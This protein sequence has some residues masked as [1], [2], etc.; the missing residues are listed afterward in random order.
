MNLKKLKK[1]ETFFKF[2]SKKSHKA[3][4]FFLLI[5]SIYYSLAIGKSWDEDF[6]LF[7]GKVTLDYLF[8]FGKIDKDYLYREYFSTI[9]WSLKYFLTLIFP[10]KYQIEISHLINLI[11]SLSGI[12]AIG[13]LSKELFNKKVGKIVFL[14]LFFYP[15]FFGHMAFN[16]KDMVLAVCHV[17]IFYLVI[18]YLKKQN[19]KDKSNY[20]VIFLGMLAAIATGIHIIFL[21]ALI[22]IFLFVLIEIFILKK[23]ISKSF[24]KKKLYVDLIKT[25]LI[26]Y[27]LLI[28]F[29]IDT[30]PNI[31]ILP[32]NIFLEHFKLLSG[33][34]WRGWPYNLLNGQYYL[35]WQVPKLH[36][37]I[38]LIYKSPEYFLACYI[39]FFIIFIKSNIFF[40]NKFQFFN[41]KLILLISI[42]IIPFII[43]FIIP[44]VIYDGMRH[45]LWVVPYYCIIP[46]LTIYYLIE[47]FNLLKSKLALT[48]LSLFIIY[49]LFNFF[50]ITPYQYTYLNLFNGKVEN[51]Y[52]KFENDYWASSINEL[53]KHSDFDKDKT[54]KFVTCGIPS[55]FPR[56]DLKKKGYTNFIFSH[57]KQADYI[58]MT[59]RTAHVSGN[60]SLESTNKTVKIIN[61]FDKF[62]GKDIFKVK[63]NGL[64]LSVIRKKTQQDNWV[65]E[66]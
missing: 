10:Y 52:K 63:R 42:M 18:K 16:D 41:Y 1:T 51:R 11:F 22:P 5:F 37:L 61:C 60:L 48:L 2:N 45:F 14:I 28:L 34:Q 3:F 36:F 55:E 7:Q 13:K 30:H 39:I 25:F 56:N 31:F 20:Y 57:P 26:F 19:I 58:I 15:I 65:S 12:I 23:F 54:L 6:Q 46:G 40:K 47:N 53:I 4:L 27:F 35:S 21:G 29:W 50:L 17:W 64:L 43:G 66:K 33:E 49:F 24:S 32:I 8:S 44:L 62:K 9:Y 59:N 38:N